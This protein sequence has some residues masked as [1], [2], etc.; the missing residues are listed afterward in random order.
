MAKELLK[1][2]L[3]EIRWCKLLEARKQFDETKPL[4]YSCELLLDNDNTEH[5]AWLAAMEDQY[6]EIH[7]NTK[8]SV[9]AFPWGPD[10]EKPKERTVV[11]FKLPEFTRKDGTKSEG[12]TLMDSRKTPWDRSVEI[13]NGSKVIIAF[14]IY[15]WQ[16]PTGNGM[17]FQPRAA[18]I[19]DLVEAPNRDATT[20][21]DVVEGGFAQACP[22]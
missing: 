22:F 17:T 16:S 11:K 8:K 18:M 12:P 2:P 7:G 4:A 3:A 14:D 9:H 5:Q 20:A 10:K 6:A 13:G 19:V 1:T 15:G 21:F